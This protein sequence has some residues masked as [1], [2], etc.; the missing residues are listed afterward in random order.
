MYLYLCIY[1]GFKK[2]NVYLII[3]HYRF[4]PQTTG[5]EHGFDIW[6]Q[7]MFYILHMLCPKGFCVTTLTLAF[8]TKLY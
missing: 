3:I 2:I 6:K 5:I 8:L 1:Y 4:L 7:I